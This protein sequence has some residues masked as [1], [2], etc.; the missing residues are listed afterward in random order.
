ML[1][2]PTPMIPMRR[3]LLLSVFC[4]TFTS[5]PAQQSA[6]EMDEMVIRSTPLGQTLFEQVQ[7]VSVL[8]GAGLASRLSASLGETLSG[9]PGVTGTGFA[10]GASRP[11]IRG[12]GEDRI[13]IVN[14]GVGV[15]DVSNVS[16]D[17][18]VTLDP[19]LMDK[20]EVVRGPAALLYG[21]NGVGGVVNVW[22][23]AFL[24]ARSSQ[25]WRA[26]RFK[27][28]WIRATAAAQIYGRARGC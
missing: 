9:L 15:L 16:P 6:V 20:I 27:G 5:L 23:V 19:L 26:C 4:L 8:E 17:H 10:P 18:A 24:L 2:Y 22:M 12:L 21:P 7:P 13:K 14:N 1:A 25:A 28:N 3:I 11:V